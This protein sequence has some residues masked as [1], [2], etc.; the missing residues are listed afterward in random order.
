MAMFAND[1]QIKKAYEVISAPDTTNFDFQE[2]LRGMEKN[3]PHFG[4]NDDKMEE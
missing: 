4:T 1:P 3:D 2:F